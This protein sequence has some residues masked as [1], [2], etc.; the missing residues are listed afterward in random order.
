MARRPGQPGLRHTAPKPGPVHRHAPAPAGLP[1]NYQEFE[2]PA[3]DSAFQRADDWARIVVGPGDIQ[4]LAI[5]TEGDGARTR[6]RP[7]MP[8]GGGEVRVRVKTQVTR[9]LNGTKHHLA[10]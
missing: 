8:L 7:E 5:L 2:V 6:P 1:G 3:A 9:V 10:G 4:R